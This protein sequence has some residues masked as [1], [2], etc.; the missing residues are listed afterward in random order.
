MCTE[1]F[2]R[3]RPRSYLVGHTTHI[4]RPKPQTGPLGSIKVDHLTYSQPI[5][6][7]VHHFPVSWRHLNATWPNEKSDLWR[8]TLQRRFLP[9][10]GISHQRCFLDSTC[11][12]WQITNPW[13]P[14]PLLKKKKKIQ[15]YVGLSIM[16]LFFRVKGLSMLLISSGAKLWAC[17]RLRYCGKVTGICSYGNF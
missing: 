6:T 16:L 8:E 9:W 3:G 17:W 11:L 10:P 14:L 13:G 2:P 15:P 12:K 4:N 7:V 5:D 1:I